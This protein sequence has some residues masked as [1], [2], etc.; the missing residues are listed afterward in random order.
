M[1]LK[2]FS[3]AVSLQLLLNS[4]ILS[5][6]LP[7]TTDEQPIQ[8]RRGIALQEGYISY[9]EYYS[10]K[11]M[12]EEK[13]R[14]FPIE[15]TGVWTELNPKVPRVD[16]LGIHFINKDTGWAVGG[17]GAL[18]K[19]TNGGSSWTVSQ[20]NTTTLL[21][22]IHSYNG[23]LVICTGYDGLILRSSDGG[24]TF[25][26]VISGVGT[27][28]DLW[29]V[30]MINDTLGWVCGLNQ[31][32]LKTTD[33]GLS[34]QQVLTGENQHYWAL[35][36]LNEQY[37]MIACGGGIILKTTDGGNSWY[38][39]LTGDNRP[40][41][42]IDLIDSLHI[43]AAGEYGNEMQYEGGKNVYSSDGGESWILNPDI[44]TY[45]DANWIEYVDIDT[46]YSIN[47]YYGIYK[48]TNRGES[49]IGVGGGGKWHIEMVGYETG[50]SGG[51]GLNIYKR[52]NGL[53][54]WGKIFLNHNWS[55]VFF[56]NELKGYIAS[57]DIGVKLY[58]TEDGGNTYQ[59][60]ENSPSRISDILFLDSL[61]GF[62]GSNTIYKT[63]DGGV[64][65]YSTNGAT[66][67]RKIF[68]INETTGWAI[69]GRTIYKTT[70]GGENWFVQITQPSDSYTSIYFTDSLNGWAT[71]RYVWQTTDGGENWIERTDIPIDF[72]TDIYFPNLNT[73]WIARYSSVNPSLFKSTN[74]GLNWEPVYEVSGVLKIH[75]FPNPTHWLVNAVYFSVPKVYITGDSGNTWLDISD[76]VPSGFNN[77]NSVTDNLGFAIGNKGL[78]LR[79]D[80]TTFV[81][82]ELTSF[83]SETNND[84]VLL[85]WSTST[86]TNNSG[87][88]VLR[89]TD[90][91]NWKS[92]GFIDGNG[93]TTLSHHYQFTDQVE[94]PGI[95]YY[96]LKQIDYSGDFQYSNIIEV[97]VN[98]PSSFELSQNFPN[99]FNP[100]TNISIKVPIQSE[101]KI[102]L[103]DITGQEIKTITN[104]KYEAG[105]HS[106]VINADD[107]SSGVYLYRMTT[108]S[109]YTAI[110]K[111]T[112]IK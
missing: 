77:F 72:S 6:T 78:I 15:S 7:D 38:Q 91:Q 33:A 101:V 89:T 59:I 53:E 73:G 23:Q 111:L 79:Y 2:S 37:G 97:S 28:I 49:W 48:T 31:T 50:Y 90:N 69:H 24:E 105:F 103:Y 110:K 65:W 17:L 74:S 44:P 71:S 43:A 36:F 58:K 106:V 39:R 80:D 21:L 47:L 25:E 63:T 93:T 12:L 86:E 35:E 11:D 75:L 82:V 10:G 56:T 95:Y 54:N 5:Q 20:T 109:G 81:P 8:Y 64:S 76:D 55:D 104:Q 45:D 40:L 51:E 27:G 4:F 67:A 62:L 16:Y 19:T 88:E 94:L 29:G 13:R 26:Q 18:I 87:F 22:K 112:I 70:D 52:T 34:W 99:P 96:K 102:I 14:L 108:Q 85:R 98:S 84:I 60:I 30:Q 107:L 3:A 61:T 32:L 100:V 68:F 57:T 83:Y 41:Y 1:K 46:G 42:T 92:L 9:D 66:G